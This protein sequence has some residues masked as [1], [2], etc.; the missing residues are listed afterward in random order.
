MFTKQVSPR[1]RSFGV[2]AVLATA[3]SAVVLGACSNAEPDPFEG[4]PAFAVDTPVIEV[5]ERGENPRQ[6]RYTDAASTSGAQDDAAWTLDVTVANGVDQAVASAKDDVALD[7]PAGG[8]VLETTLPLTV[9]VAGAG[10]PGAGETEAARAVTIQAGA[11]K[12][13][14]LALGQQIASA[15]GFLMRWRAAETGLVS[16]VQLFAPQDSPERG[17]QA[18]EQALLA[19]MSSAVV[20]PE[21][22]IGI[23]GSWAVRGRATG[24]TT[25]QRT[26]TYT[27][28]GIDGDRVELD[29]DVEEQPAQ[30]TL[31]IDNQA[32]GGLDGQT[33]SVQHASTTSDGALSVDLAHPLPVAGRSAATTRLIYA[34]DGA[35]FRVVQDITH[36]VTYG[37]R[38]GK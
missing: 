2:L 24:D 6:L 26:T 13:S 27:V 12:A 15:E 31:R 5:L 29:V 4:I 11:G 33:L 30:D 14:D 3:A 37:T 32:A 9:S 20:F 28:T 23:G 22:P 19:V 7:A 36:A 1:S 35:D 10:E 18:V 16:S 25:M 21:E 34:G 8:D 17:R 38:S